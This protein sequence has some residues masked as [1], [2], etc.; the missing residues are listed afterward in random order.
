MKDLFE[1]KNCI[2]TGGSTGIGYGLSKR[3]LERGA[4]VW[5][6]SRTAKNMDSVREEFK[7]FGDRAHFDVI[8]VRDADRVTAYINGIAQKGPIDYL[9]NNAG[10]GFRGR[11]TE[12]TPQMWENVMS[13]NLYGV[14][15][16]CD[17]AVPI[18]LAQGYGHIVNISSLCGFVPLPYQTIYAAS[19]YAVVG[20][21][22]ALRYEYEEKNIR[23]T[24]V[25]PGPVESM[26]FYRSQDYSLVEWES[27]A[28]PPE[29]LT[30]EQ[31]ADEILAGVAA[32]RGLLP[33]TDMAR[34]YYENLAKDPTAN[35]EKLRALRKTVEDDFVKLGI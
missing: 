2:V 28:P 27:L 6:C 15:Y 34:E 12:T 18:M 4:N 7:R 1:G 20:F 14:V 29:S 13:V 23:V 9:F 26:I 19:K 33:I 35:A 17:A 21:S 32:N 30:P 25:C 5:L 22:E 24:V 16:G 31:A 10:V 11:F 8:D 3:L